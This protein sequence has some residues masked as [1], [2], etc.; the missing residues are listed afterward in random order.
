MICNL[1]TWIQNL[2]LYY[3]IIIIM[4]MMIMI[5]MIM[6]M[7]MIMINIYFQIF[8]LK[9]E[10]CFN[11]CLWNVYGLVTSRLL[12]VLIWLHFLGNEGKWIILLIFA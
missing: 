8:W 10:F 12:F 6:I 9:F 7:I 5:I 4:M 11:C 2:L 3:I 1:C